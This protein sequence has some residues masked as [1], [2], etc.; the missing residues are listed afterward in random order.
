MKT[1][2][3]NQKTLVVMAFVLAGLFMFQG[4]SLA[5]N[6]ISVTAIN[7]TITQLNPGDVLDTPG[8]AEGEIQTF[9]EGVEATIPRIEERRQ[10]ILE[11]QRIPEPSQPSTPEAS[12]VI[13]GGG[14]ISTL[15]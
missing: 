3:K 6:I 10:P 9:D 11:G 2:S 1:L 15:Q 14:E 13:E 5:A 7:G 4:H 8:S 12:P